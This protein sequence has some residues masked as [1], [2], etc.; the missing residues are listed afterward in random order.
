MKKAAATIVCISVAGLFNG[1][2]DALKQCGAHCSMQLDQGFIGSHWTLP[3]G[4]YL[5]HIVPAAARATINKTTMQHVPTLLAILMAIAMRRYF[6]V[7]IA[8]WRSCAAFIKATK[9]RHRGYP[10][11][12]SNAGRVGHI[13]VKKSSS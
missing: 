10:I 4:N 5:L 1:H 12:H 9:C 7:R 2:T 3:L 6:T 13:A 8:R 11:G